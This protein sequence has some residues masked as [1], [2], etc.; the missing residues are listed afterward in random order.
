LLREQ[1]H[2]FQDDVDARMVRVTRRQQLPQQQAFK[3]H[4]LVSQQQQQ[5]KLV[6]EDTEDDADTSTVSLSMVAPTP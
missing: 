4:V 5:V 3:T 1:Q 2:L 6:E